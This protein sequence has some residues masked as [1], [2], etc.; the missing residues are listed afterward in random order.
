[1]T[2]VVVHVVDGRVTAQV[3]DDIAGE[4]LRLPHRVLG[5][6]HTVAADAVTGEVGHR[7]HVS[8]TPRVRNHAVIAHDT[9][10][11]VHT[12]AAALLEGEVGAAQHRTRHDAGRPDE[13]VG[14]EPLARGELHDSVFG[15]RELRLQVQ[16]N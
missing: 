7:G 9:Q 13:C 8:G 6:R 3:G 15:A 1:R 4:T 14:G 11:G 12:E 10:V 5:V 2:Q 16:H